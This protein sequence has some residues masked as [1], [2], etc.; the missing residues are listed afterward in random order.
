MRS[1]KARSESRRIE[2]GITMIDDVIVSAMEALALQTK[3]TEHALGMWAMFTML[4]DFDETKWNDMTEDERSD[5]AS[6]YIPTVSD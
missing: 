4:C 1:R 3:N 2:G 6:Q 5:W